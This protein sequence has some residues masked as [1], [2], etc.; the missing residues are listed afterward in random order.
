MWSV[1]CTI[2]FLSNRSGQV[3]IERCSNGHNSQTTR[4]RRQAHARGHQRALPSHGRRKVIQESH[5]RQGRRDRLRGAGESHQ[6]VH[7]GVWTT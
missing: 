4:L 1:L 3:E 5:L 2:L 7:Q 6:G